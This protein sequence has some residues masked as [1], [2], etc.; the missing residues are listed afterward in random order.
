MSDPTVSVVITARERFSPTLGCWSHLRR[1]SPSHL[2]WIAVDNGWPRSVKQDVVGVEWV[3]A[4]YYAPPNL[5]RNVGLQA[6]QGEYVVFIDNDVMVTSGWLEALLACATES[7]A[8]IV[9]PLYMVG[10]RV[11]M[12]GGSLR[13]EEGPSGRAMWED[14]IHVDRR[15]DELNLSRGPVDYVEFHC[16]LA[17][18]GAI[19]GIDENLL[20]LYEYMD[21]CRA[22]TV[23]VEPKSEVTYL[24]PPPFQAFDIPYFTLRWSEAWNLASAL[25]F[26]SRWGVVSITSG[27]RPAGEDSALLWARGHRRRLVG[28]R[29]Q[30]VDLLPAE[31]LAW[32]VAAFMSVECTCFEVRRG[33]QCDIKTGAEL[34]SAAVDIDA[35][36]PCSAMPVLHANAPAHLSFLTTGTTGWAAVLG[37]SPAPLP[38]IEIGTPVTAATLGRVVTAAQWQPAAWQES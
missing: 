18:R 38:W 17:R 3:E 13:F 10:D 1:H 6:A 33:G 32:M 27:G 34:L 36:R 20:S 2:Q 23:F 4:P 21:V 16:L 26:K 11:H 9:G 14:H 28:T 31:H 8:D 30:P 22:R 24:S 15:K 37:S 12:A 7:K 35:L 19:E 29:W 5:A 25:H